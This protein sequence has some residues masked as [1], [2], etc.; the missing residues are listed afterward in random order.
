MAETHS[1][2][3]NRDRKLEKRGGVPRSL[4]AITSVNAA[5]NEAKAAVQAAEAKTK[6]MLADADAA[7]RAAVEAAGAKADAELREL[8]RKAEEKYPIEAA[9]QPERLGGRKA[10]LRAQ[11]G[12]KLGRAAVLIVERIVNN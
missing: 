1:D 2:T 7:G 9:E 4:E 11:A 10:A 12:E 8:R 6:Q 3:E 5:E